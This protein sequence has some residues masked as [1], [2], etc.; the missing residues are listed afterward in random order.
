LHSWKQRQI[1][2]EREARKAR[3][4]HM[5][6]E[7]ETNPVLERRIREIRDGVKDNGSAFFSA[8]VERL[9]KQPGPE[10]PP[11]PLQGTYDSLVLSLLR[12]MVADINEKGIKEG[13]PRLIEEILNAL[14]IHLDRMPEYQ[15]TTRDALEKEE[16]DQKK[17]ITSDDIRPGFDSTVSTLSFEQSS[18]FDF[19]LLEYLY[20]TCPQ[21]QSHLQF[22][23]L[24]VKLKAPRRQLQQNMKF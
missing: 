23:V 24:K 17:K 18:L 9:E 20:S 15:K 19:F 7:L 2:E 5:K 6:A 12:K 8:T 21:S 14:E 13:D 22:Q 11:A 10:K 4:A 16:N 3:I 1:H